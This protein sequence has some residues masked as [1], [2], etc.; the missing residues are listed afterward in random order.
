MTGDGVNDAPA[1]KKAPPPP[2]PNP[3][4]TP[5][6]TPPPPL[7]PPSPTSNARHKDHAAVVMSIFVTLVCEFR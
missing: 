5:T 4:P 3:P 7:P 2:T 6:P 1:L